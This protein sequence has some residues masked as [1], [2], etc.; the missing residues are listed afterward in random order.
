VDGSSY[1]PFLEGRGVGVEKEAGWERRAGVTLPFLVCLCQN[2]AAQA[3]R[4]R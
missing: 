3:W 4:R 1:T 2:G